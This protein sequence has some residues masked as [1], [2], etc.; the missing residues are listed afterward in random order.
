MERVFAMFMPTIGLYR[1][2]CVKRASEDY[3]ILF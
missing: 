1:L 2:S 3:E